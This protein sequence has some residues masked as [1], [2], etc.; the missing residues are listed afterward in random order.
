M[1]LVNVPISIIVKSAIL[2]VVWILMQM[3]YIRVSINTEKVTNCT[4]LLADLS[5][6]WYETGF[7]QRFLKKN[8]K[9]LASFF[10]FT[11]RNVFSLNNSKFYSIELEIKDTMDTA[12]CAIYV[13]LHI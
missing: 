9:K 11:F 2:G 7:I 13:Y 12:K 1:S 5:F 10:H 4:P 6:Y 8:E 3:G